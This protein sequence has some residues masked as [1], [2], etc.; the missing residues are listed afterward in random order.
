MG[1]NTFVQHP[2]SCSAMSIHCVGSTQALLQRGNKLRSRT[3]VSAR[4]I[5]A[6]VPVMDGASGSTQD[7]V[8]L[9]RAS[10]QESGL[11]KYAYD[12]SV[13]EAAGIDIAANEF[14]ALVHFRGSW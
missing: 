5:R 9:A 13:L 3:V 6:R 4:V 1:R 8:V 12:L 2:R 7:R 11:P 10:S 14:T